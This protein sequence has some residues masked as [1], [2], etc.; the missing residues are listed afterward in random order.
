[1]KCLLIAIA[2]C[3]ISGYAVYDYLNHP[4]IEEIQM[5]WML[6]GHEIRGL[7]LKY[8]KEYSDEVLYHV[9][10]GL[11]DYYPEFIEDDLFENQ[12]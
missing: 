8:E 6:C 4:D 11:L 1:M 10:D 7:E 9:C 5:T 3:I 2:L 12:A